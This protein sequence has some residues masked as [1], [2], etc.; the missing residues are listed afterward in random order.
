MLF[1]IVIGIQG[2]SNGNLYILDVNLA[3]VVKWSTVN[4]SGTI[5]AGGYGKGLGANQLNIPYGMFLDPNT[6]FIWIADT[7]NHRVVRWESPTTGII[8]GGSNGTNADQFCYPFGLFVD[9]NDA[10]TLYVADTYNHRIQRWLSGASNGTTVAGQTGV[11]GSS[12][13][14]LYY[15]TAVIG[16]G[17]RNLYILSYSTGSIVKWQVGA[18]VGTLIV[19]TLSTGSSSN[20]LNS[21]YNFKFGPD[22]SIYVPDTANNR[23]QKFSAICCKFSV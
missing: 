3:R 7:S 14:V 6:M 10:N 22:Y 23:T 17:N 20:Q 5:V 18:T 16:E 2:D 19:G 12:L 13:S 11:A 8:V 21:P 1:V 9:T 15:P 4:M